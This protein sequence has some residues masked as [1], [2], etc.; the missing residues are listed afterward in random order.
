MLCSLQWLLFRQVTATALAILVL[1]S[2][3]DTPNI[4]FLWCNPTFVV[5][6]SGRTMALIWCVVAVTCNNTIGTIVCPCPK[7]G[8]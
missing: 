4:R 3:L 6:H 7:Y 2:W 1:M 5:H 8:I